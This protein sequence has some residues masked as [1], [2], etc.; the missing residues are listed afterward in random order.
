MFIAFSLTGCAVDG[1]KRLDTVSYVDLERFMGD[2]YVVA[3]I[4]AFIEKGAHN[5]VESYA[6]NSDGTIATTFRFN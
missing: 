4:P 6:L 5:A 1:R 2:W 3:S